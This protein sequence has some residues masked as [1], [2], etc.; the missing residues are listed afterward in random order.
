VYPFTEPDN[1]DR[2]DWADD[3][4]TALITAAQRRAWPLADDQ[5]ADAYNDM[6][7]AALA[8]FGAATRHYPITCFDG[9]VPGDDSDREEAA[10]ILSDFSGDLRHLLDRHDLTVEQILTPPPG[11]DVPQVTAD[12]HLAARLVWACIHEYAEAAGLDFAELAYRGMRH[13]HDEVAEQAVYVPVE[14]IPP[15]HPIPPHS[16]FASLRNLHDRYVWTVVCL[17]QW[18]RRRTAPRQ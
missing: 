4:L 15:R 5:R 3:A 12:V 11:P 7:R 18:L 14:P 1:D 8:D 6:A 17:A 2:A 10:E 16:V 13:H 9:P